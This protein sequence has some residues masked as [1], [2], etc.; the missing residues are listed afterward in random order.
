MMAARITPAVMPP[1]APP[2]AELVELGWAK[3]FRRLLTDWIRCK[4][5]WGGRRDSRA[6][7]KS[8]KKGV[9]KT[10]NKVAK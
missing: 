9:H 10:G 5:R 8:Y 1:L 3:T 6:D 7:S 4:K 2:T